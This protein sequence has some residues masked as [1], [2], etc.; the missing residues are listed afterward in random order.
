M[1][2]ITGMTVSQDSGNAGTIMEVTSYSLTPSTTS[3]R[4]TGSFNVRVTMSQ[5]TWVGTHSSDSSYGRQVRG[6]INGHNIGTHIIKPHA[7]V[8]WNQSGV[9]NYTINVDIPYSPGTVYAN[10]RIERQNGTTGGTACFNPQLNYWTMNSS[11]ANNPSAVRN[12]A[13]SGESGTTL[14]AYMNTIRSLTWT[15]PVS[16]GTGSIQNYDVF[17]TTGNNVWTRRARLSSGARSYAL[18][19]SDYS[20]PRGGHV[21]FDVRAIGLYG[22]SS[23]SNIPA[24]R[25]SPLPVRPSSASIPSQANFG[26]TVTLSWTEGTHGGSGISDYRIEYRRRARGSSTWGSWTY[27]TVNSGLSQNVTPSSHAQAIMPGDSVQYRVFT[28]DNLGLQSSTARDSGILTMRGGIVRIRV[29]GTWREGI[30]WIRVSGTWR[31]AIGAYQRVS[32]TWR[33]GI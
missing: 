8:A 12:T 20:I 16:S 17:W 4:T 10:I 1:P 26:Q 22:N 25:L 2:D 5:W 6:T 23:S 11:W 21:W 28:R 24:I 15:A 14:V 3:K 7:T 30:A 13:I 19:L 27:L 18:I 9:Y 29:G 31:E 33:E 32:G